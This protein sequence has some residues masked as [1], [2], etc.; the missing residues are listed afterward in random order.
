MLHDYSNL[1][2]TSPICV[3]HSAP[4]TLLILFTISL[5]ASL[6]LSSA[7]DAVSSKLSALVKLNKNWVAQRHSSLVFTPY[8]SVSRIALSVSVSISVRLKY[9]S[10]CFTGIFFRYANIVSWF[11][12]RWRPVKSLT[13]PA[14]VLGI[15]CRAVCVYTANAFS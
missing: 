13:K 5:I 4:A 15:V 14:A 1:K 6:S 7:N 12:P 2:T 10:I 11:L 3:S 9:A 8:F